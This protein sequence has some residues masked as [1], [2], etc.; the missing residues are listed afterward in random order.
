MNG[1][2]DLCP[3]PAGGASPLN[4]IET[5]AFETV[6]TCLQNGWT[7]DVHSAAAADGAARCDSEYRLLQLWSVHEESL[8]LFQLTNKDG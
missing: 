8:G 4:I 6:R 7:G 1:P 3:G 2:P 5:A